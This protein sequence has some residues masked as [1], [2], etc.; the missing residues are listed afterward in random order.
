MKKKTHYMVDRE[1]C[2]KLVCFLNHSTY[3]MMDIFQGDIKAMRIVID[4][5]PQAD[6]IRFTFFEEE[7]AH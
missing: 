2:E 5:D 3:P 4:Y 1:F 7:H 6:K